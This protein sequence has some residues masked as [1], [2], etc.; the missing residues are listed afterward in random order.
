VSVREEDWRKELPLSKP[1]QFFIGTF[2][3][4]ILFHS[5]FLRTQDGGEGVARPYGCQIQSAQMKALQ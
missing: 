4:S 2:Q 1:L 5:P 3:V